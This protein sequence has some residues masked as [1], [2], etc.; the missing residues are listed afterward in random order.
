MEIARASNDRRTERRPAVL[1]ALSFV[2][3]RRRNE[4]KNGRTESQNHRDTFHRGGGHPPPLCS[5]LCT[6]AV[7][8]N[9]HTTPSSSCLSIR[10]HHPACTNSASLAVHVP[11]RKVG[12]TE[13]RPERTSVA[14]ES[15]L[16]TLWIF[17]KAV[18]SQLILS[19]SILQIDQ[20]LELGFF[21]IQRVLIG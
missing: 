18:S 11:D 4:R 14:R 9:T 5:C 2:R 8:R 19:Y 10:D 16:H 15:L 20:L 13:T 17:Y 3:G 21:F 7:A 12:E 6:T 1:I